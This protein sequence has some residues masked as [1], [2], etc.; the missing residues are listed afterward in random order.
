M[1]SYLRFSLENMIANKYLNSMPNFA[2]RHLAA[3]SLLYCYLRCS[4]SCTKTSSLPFLYMHISIYSEVNQVAIMVTQWGN[5]IARWFMNTI[6]FDTLYVC[7][8]RTIC[9]HNTRKTHIRVHKKWEKYCNWFLEM[10][11]IY[12][13]C[14]E[15]VL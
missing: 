8:I 6:R 5:E 13:L 3:V 7:I 2:K 4:R 14:D 9:T 1:L 10:Y 11:F 12:V 15:M